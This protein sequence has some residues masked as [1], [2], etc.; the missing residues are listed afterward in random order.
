LAVELIYPAAI[1]GSTMRASFR[2]DERQPSGVSFVIDRGTS[3][4]I[5]TGGVYVPISDHQSPRRHAGDLRRCAGSAPQQAR[6][7]R[8]LLLNRPIASVADTAVTATWSRSRPTL[9]RSATTLAGATTA[10]TATS[11]ARR[12]RPNGRILMSILT[13]RC[14]EMLRIRLLST[15]RC[16]RRT[17]R[18]RQRSSRIDNVTPSGLLYGKVLPWRQYS[19]ANA[20]VELLTKRLSQFDVALDGAVTA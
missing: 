18:F 8:P 19:F 1:D 10:R 9:L 12:C 20:P 14:R 4:I 16:C 2:V 11:P 17:V 7:G 3:N 6:G 13:K 15:I 5:V